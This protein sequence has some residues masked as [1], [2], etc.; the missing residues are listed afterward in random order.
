MDAES[1][2]D[3]LV[4]AQLG[5]WMHHTVQGKLH[6]AGRFEQFFTDI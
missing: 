5:A 6:A 4:V 3:T 2:K 1:V